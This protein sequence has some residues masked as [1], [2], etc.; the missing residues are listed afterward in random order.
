MLE[1]FTTAPPCRRKPNRPPSEA[2]KAIAAA[3]RAEH[4]PVTVDLARYEELVTP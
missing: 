2:A 4:P 3:L 1:Q